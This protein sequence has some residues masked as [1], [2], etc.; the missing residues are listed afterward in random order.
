MAN[1]CVTSVSLLLSKKKVTDSI[2]KVKKDQLQD[3]LD[4]SDS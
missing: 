2:P 1:Q 3:Q 4:C